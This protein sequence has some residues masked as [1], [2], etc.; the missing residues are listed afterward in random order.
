MF[1]SRSAEQSSRL[2]SFVL[3]ASNW[4]SPVPVGPYSVPKTTDDFWRQPLSCYR[5]LPP[6]FLIHDHCTAKQ[7]RNAKVLSGAGDRHQLFKQYRGTTGTPRD[8][9]STQ[10]KKDDWNM[11]LGQL[12]LCQPNLGISDLS[13]CEFPDMRDGD[14][15]CRGARPCWSLEFFEEDRG[16]TMRNKWMVVRNSF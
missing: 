7:N 16:R 5:S 14:R 8:T 11:L 2:P 1:S 4:E 10:T 3:T 13:N 15:E 12:S 9:L 6:D